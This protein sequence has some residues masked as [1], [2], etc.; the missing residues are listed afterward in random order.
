MLPSEPGETVRLVAM[1]YGLAIQ[2]HFEELP[3]LIF[4][5]HQIVIINEWLHT[6][7]FSAALIVKLSGEIASKFLI[8][9]SR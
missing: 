1:K 6:L 5:E 2:I 4:W 3:Y 8:D 7:L 9:I